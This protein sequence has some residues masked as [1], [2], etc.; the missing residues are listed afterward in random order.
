MRQ[1]LAEVTSATLRHAKGLLVGECVREDWVRSALCWVAHAVRPLTPMELAVAV[2]LEEPAMR[3]VRDGPTPTSIQR[4][5]TLLEHVSRDIVGDLLR[6]APPPVRLVGNRIVPIHQRLHASLCGSDD[7]EDDNR[8]G[9]LS[10]PHYAIL[11]SC[12]EYLEWPT[13]PSTTGASGS[14]TSLKPA[15]TCASSSMTVIT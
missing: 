12:L 3:S 13:S 11:A 14:A 7:D 9:K 15:P 8:T 10:D 5:H 6:K 4:Q 2:A 1:R